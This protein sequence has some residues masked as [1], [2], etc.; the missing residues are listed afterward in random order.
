MCPEQAAM[1]TLVMMLWRG[2]TMQ[3]NNRA[4][5]P[6]SS[7]SDSRR[8]ITMKRVLREVRD[9]YTIITEQHDPRRISRQTTTPSEHTVAVTTQ[10][11]LDGYREKTMRIASIE[12]N[13]LNWVSNAS[14]GALDMTNRDFSVRSAQDAIRHCMSEAVS[15]MSSL[16]L[17]KIRT[18]DARDKDKDHLKFLCKLCEASKRRAVATSCM[19]RHQE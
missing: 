9:E 12:N 5:H 3:T 1:M 18:E 8:R 17:T 11:A 4:E 13:T 15:S 2:K 6:R 14:A 7:G 16:C 19:S 10:E